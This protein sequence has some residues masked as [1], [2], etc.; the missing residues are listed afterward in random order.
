MGMHPN[1]PPLPQVGCWP[2]SPSTPWGHGDTGTWGYGDTAQL[3]CLWTSN[4]L[5]MTAQ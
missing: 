3:S 2:A 5:F 4:E 1:L